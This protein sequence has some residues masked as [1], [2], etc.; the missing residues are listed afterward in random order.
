MILTDPF[1]DINLLYH[2]AP[3]ES[4]AAIS[5]TPD[6]GRPTGTETRGP[7]DP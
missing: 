7:A 1:H 2:K 6:R 3:I 4:C 5:T